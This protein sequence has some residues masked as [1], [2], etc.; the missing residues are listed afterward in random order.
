MPVD[1]KF[2][3]ENYEKLMDAY[4]QGEKTFID[5]AQKEINKNN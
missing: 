3:I 4:E 5:I 1:S 2:P